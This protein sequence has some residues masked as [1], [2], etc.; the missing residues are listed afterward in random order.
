MASHV[1]PH[2]HTVSQYDSTQNTCKRNARM[3][4]ELAGKIQQEASKLQNEL[5]EAGC[6]GGTL[7]GSKSRMPRQSQILALRATSPESTALC[8]A[9]RGK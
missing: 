6:S 1:V 3:L 7:E 2:R 9:S 8:M 5:N 4:Q